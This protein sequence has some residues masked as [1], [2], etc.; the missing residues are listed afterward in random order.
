[1]TD[2]TPPPPGYAS[3]P[4]LSIL[5]GPP[6][7]FT[8]AGQS[9]SGTSTVTPPAHN[10]FM[11]DLA[12]VQAAEQSLLNAAAAIIAAYNPLD[13]QVQADIQAGT[14]FGQQATYNGL[15]INPSISGDPHP[16]V[17][18]NSDHEYTDADE[19]LQQGALQF[20][21]SMNP[22]MTRVLRMIADATEA[23]GVF[24]AFLDKAGQAYAFADKNSVAP[25][26][27]VARPAG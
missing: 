7:A 27:V 25:T 26:P 6:P 20:A 21:A 9:A 13:Q 8:G 3:D 22:S 17:G 2:P 15:Y 24:I 18:P 16:Y 1:M 14:I 4:V 10:D 5:W 19:Q 12:S 23:V 11:V